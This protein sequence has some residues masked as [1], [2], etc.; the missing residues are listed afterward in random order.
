M[1]T[2]VVALL[3]ESFL[4]SVESH[5]RKKGGGEV[6]TTTT[7]LLPRHEIITQVEKNPP[8]LHSPPIFVS[9]FKKKTEID[10]VER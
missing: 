9:L 8:T 4:F 5:S 2:K 1:K 7:Q 10:F 3:V 6:T